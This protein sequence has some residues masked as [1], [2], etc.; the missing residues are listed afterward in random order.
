MGWAACNAIVGFVVG[1]FGGL[2][3]L[4]GAELRL[5]YLVGVLRLGAHRAVP[6]NLAVS[7]FTILTAIPPRLAVAPG[8]ALAP[9]LW[10]TI[11][12]AIGAIVAAYVGASY[13][14]RL[15]AGALGRLI[16]VLLVALGVALLVEAAVPFASDGLLPNLLWPRLAAG[17]LLGVGIGAISS[18]LGVAG[19]E[20]IIPT[21]AFGYGVPIVTAGSLSL[22]I[23]VPMVVVGILR[24][25]T[26]GAYAERPLLTGLIVPMG[27]GSAGGATVGALLV[28]F[29][30]AAL[31]KAGLGILLIL[32]AWKVF[33]K[34]Q[35]REATLATKP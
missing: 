10:G 29:A 21:L 16:F 5:P 4:G 17:L 26:A 35:R 23:S 24:H 28:A 13:L 30:P 15:S 32:S 31:I 1:V 12:I 25:A 33:A 3:G 27:L 14:G 6:V 22:M 19:G 34:G 20:V 18:V 2:I 8:A 9:F 11:V 7:L